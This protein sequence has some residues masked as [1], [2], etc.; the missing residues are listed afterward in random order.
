MTAVHLANNKDNKTRCSLCKIRSYSFCRCLN[1]DQLE[2]FSKVSFEKKFTD[3]ENIF[4]QNDSSTHLYNITEGNVKIYQLLDDGRIQIIGFLYPGD[5]FGTYKNNKYN[6]SAEAIGNLRVCVF[7]QRV[8]DKYMDQNP[9]LAKELLNQTSYELTLA[10]DRMTVMG[11]LNAIEKIAIFFINISNQRKRIGWQS[12]P[13]S[14]SMT[15][16][17]IA[18]YLGLTIE[19]V[20]RE[21]SKLKTSNIIKIISSKQLFIKDIEK[22]KQISKL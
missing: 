18:D 21:I 9:I 8:L 11:R 19:T 12:N 5:F 7:D 15:R 2:I 4:L 1:D 22:L 3:K 16:Q 17:D 14:L 6:Y 13:I 20:S 10:Q